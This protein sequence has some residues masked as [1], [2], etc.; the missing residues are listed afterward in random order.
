[1]PY[2]IALL[3]NQNCGKTTLFNRLTGAHRHVGNY[4]GVTVDAKSGTI[5][6]DGEF[7]IVDLP[8]IY[9]LHPYSAEE[10]VSREFL[11]REKPDGIINIADANCLARGLFL[12]LQIIDMGIP[13]VLALNMMDEVRANGGKIDTDALSGMLGV[14]VVAISAG[15]GDGTDELLAALKKAVTH[16][17][18]P[19]PCDYYGGSIGDCVNSVCRE[20]FPYAEKAGLSQ[21]FCAVAALEEDREV[22][23]RLCLDDS[24]KRAIRRE[25]ESAESA[26]KSDIYTLLAR[27]KYSFIEKAVSRCV[28]LPAESREKRRSEKIDKV[29]TDR[30]LAIPLFLLIIS[31]VFFLTFNVIGGRLQDLADCSLEALTCLVRELLFSLGVN[32]GL[33]SLITDGIFVGVGSVLSFLPVILVL[34]FFLSVLEDSGYMARVAFITDGLFGKVGLSGKS[35]VPLLM[36]F[37]CTVPA[38][39]ATRTLPSERD[40]RVTMML[41]PY[42]SCSAKI[43]IYSMFASVF[44]TR[45]KW[46]LMVELYI[47][48]IVLALVAAIV[49]KRAYPEKEES[50]FLMEL[51]NYRFPSAAS[52]L[53]L[54]WEKAKDFISRA[55]TVILLSS[56]VVWVL[57]HFG[58]GFSFVSESSHSLLSIIGKKLSVVFIPIGFNRPELVAALLVGLTAKESV[59]STLGVLAGKGGIASLFSGKLSAFSFLLFTL[60]YTPCVAAFS[61]VKGELHSL[62]HALFFA[63]CQCAVAYFTSFIFYNLSSLL[64]SLI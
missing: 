33:T 54:M 58:V 30:Y 50:G 13:T 23:S 49:L 51:P 4:P 1:M 31:A 9:S 63:L 40:R 55:F 6:S 22:I 14:P 20:I 48:G 56:V 38:V 7:E 62:R 36:G 27:E 34:F 5:K 64:I 60:L 28:K 57:G 42:I 10:K 12:S 29:L 45:G 39:M 24:A 32:D 43:P 52:V 47:I 11:I 17:T 15:K 25:K 53:R 44:F 35:F 41:L 18:L 46:L 8:G 26:E 16:K 37:G 61:A 19:N 3:G 2:V 59:I 21:R